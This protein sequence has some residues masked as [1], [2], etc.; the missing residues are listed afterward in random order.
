MQTQQSRWLPTPLAR[1]RTGSSAACD[2]R[3]HFER[4]C[5]WWCPVRRPTA[6]ALWQSK[7]RPARPIKKKGANDDVNQTTVVSAFM[8]VT[9]DRVVGAEWFAL[10]RINGSH[11]GPSRRSRVVCTDHRVKRPVDQVPVGCVGLS[12][13]WHAVS[14]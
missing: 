6:P 4:Q 7:Q 9:L 12:W 8:I 2:T 14:E 11:A 3:Q 1:R 10:Q 5:C 13:T